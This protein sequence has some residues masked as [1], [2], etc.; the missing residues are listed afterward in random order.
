VSGAKERDDKFI[1]YCLKTLHT[2]WHAYQW[3]CYHILRYMR[4]EVEKS[5]LIREPLEWVFSFLCHTTIVMTY[6][7]HFS[8][9]Y[10]LSPP[11]T[12]GGSHMHKFFTLTFTTLS[13]YLDN[14]CCFSPYVHMYE[15]LM[16]VE[17][18]IIASLTNHWNRRNKLNNFSIHIH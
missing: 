9:S 8:L 18:A 6:K 10:S 15:K 1:R 14:C 5:N 11:Y 2:H 13:H 3:V 16:C 4:W 17:N 7:R 12:V